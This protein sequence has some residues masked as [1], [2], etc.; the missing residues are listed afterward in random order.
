MYIYI[1][2]KLQIH[3]CLLSLSKDLDEVGDPTEVPSSS[4]ETC[5]APRWSG[6]DEGCAK[7]ALILISSKV[8]LCEAMRSYVKLRNEKVASA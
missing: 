8:E 4:P 1:H 7:P 2:I 6:N 3:K 5:A